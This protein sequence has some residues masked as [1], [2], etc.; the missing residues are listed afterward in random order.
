MNF[1]YT[2]LSTK[3]FSLSADMANVDVMK[4]AHA[5]VASNGLAGILNA[6]RY[7]TYRQ[8]DFIFIVAG[9]GA[10]G[11]ENGQIQLT[12]KVTNPNGTPVCEVYAYFTGA[13]S[14]KF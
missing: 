10:I 2:P 14:V 5:V 11:A 12:L 4:A 8:D 9:F 13:L 6:P 3:P 1:V 7:V